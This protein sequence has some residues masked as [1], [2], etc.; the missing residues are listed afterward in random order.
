MRIRG[1]GLAALA[2]AAIVTFL[3]AGAAEAAPGTP[4]A[5]PAPGLD[6]GTGTATL[7]IMVTDLPVKVAASVRV[8]GPDGY[9]QAV[10]A[11]T[12]LGGLAAGTYKVS[13][14]PVK[15]PGGVTDYPTVTGPSQTLTV[16]GSA[17]STVAYYTQIPATT[18]PV[19]A[20]DITSV[21]AG[22]AGRS[23]VVVRGAAPIATGDII[24]AG[25]GPATPDGLLAKVTAVS[26]AGR[27]QTLTTMPATLRQA[28][29]RGEFSIGAP[30]AGALPR[31]TPRAPAVGVSGSHHFAC[32]TSGSLTVTP[33]I[34]TSFATPAMTAA[35]SHAGPS[36]AV[37]ANVKVSGTLTATATAGAN[38]TLKPTA[39]GQLFRFSPVGTMIGR[40]P[41]VLV[42][43][44]RFFVRGSASATAQVT[45]SVTQQL[46]TTAGLS[47]RNGHLTPA[48]SV[49]G[50]RSYTSPV[51]RGTAQVS[52]SA[53]PDITLAVYGLLG[54]AIN[55]DPGAELG[56]APSAS[57]WW[58]LYATATAGEGLDVPE[59]G[60][61][62][63]DD[64]IIT[65]R[66]LLAEAVGPQGTSPTGRELPATGL[67]E[68]LANIPT[69]PLITGPDGR[70]WM[71]ATG[72][73]SNV[74][75]DAL[76]PSTDTISQYPL[77]QTT[78]QDQIYYDG[79]L[80]FDGS[81]QVWLGA[82]DPTKGTTFLV[83]DSIT[84]GVS[85]TVSM[86]GRC[87]GSGDGGVLY[88]FY[89]ATDGS[90]WTTCANS[91]T[92]QQW[93]VRITASGT[94]TSY[95]NKTGGGIS[96]YLAP[97]PG[98]TMWATVGAPTGPI[99]SS[100][101]IV[102][103]APSG[104]VTLHQD[105]GPGQ[106]DLEVAG[107]GKTV[108]DIAACTKNGVTKGCYL[109]VSPAGAETTLADVPFDD[110]A[111]AYNDPPAMDAQGDVWVLDDGTADG[112][113]PSGQFYFE[114]TPGG[115]SAI[116]S[117]RFPAPNASAT[118]VPT[119]APVVTPDGAIWAE[120]GQPDLGYLVRVAGP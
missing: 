83:H 20:A 52:V 5:G 34:T 118:L 42:P 106:L 60:I 27:T 71:V 56:V 59:L 21:T 32:G 11:T 50:S 100:L 28:I 14:Q 44:V 90:V 70:L 48:G 37:S 76:N 66:W 16:G 29:P 95:L 101:G 63:S 88:P 74:V 103:I 87:F 1:L 119:G 19:T 17:T 99:R 108:V 30:A 93:L 81:G 41:L 112:A 84:T 33:A 23:T 36:V 35:W 38:C 78:G 62:V 107:N 39:V 98:G 53:G 24:A 9:S 15:V 114:V 94:V 54:P 10:T 45:A 64:A 115:S 97:G 80:A 96:S 3:G 47:Y 51:P 40:I 89:S 102:K 117:F 69:S 13:A 43:E 75:L 6:A 120:E 4:A 77:P 49:S 26:V 113:A 86:P 58:S 22:A 55:I 46:T 104:Q 25:T 72:A 68:G 110:V 65:R 8:T 109:N 12:A 31:R 82:E 7:D 2:A 57:P 61:D 18:Q 91:T 92:D 116:D 105:P 85:S 73:T 67:G 79:S 111:G